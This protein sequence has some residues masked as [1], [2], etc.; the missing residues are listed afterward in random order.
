LVE[1]RKDI[2]G[3]RCW[4]RIPIDS[5]HRSREDR[6]RR[7]GTGAEP[8]PHCFCLFYA[9]PN[10]FHFIPISSSLIRLF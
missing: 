1:H 8:L 6:G 2:K 10:H 3:K 9:F 4:E 7:A 5:R